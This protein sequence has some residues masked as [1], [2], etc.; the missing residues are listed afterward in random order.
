MNRRE[1][2]LGAMMIASSPIIGA[3]S[4]ASQ[5][6]IRKSKILHEVYARGEKVGEFQISLEQSPDR[7]AANVDI[8][9]QV[10][11]IGIPVYSYALSAKEIWKDGILHSLNSTV[12]AGRKKREIVAEYDGKQIL[13][14]SA[15]F[16]GV[17]DRNSATTSYFSK[18]MLKR[19]TWIS[20]DSGKP[21]NVSA[22]KSG[23]E[24]IKGI[25][26]EVWKVTGDLELDLFYSKDG[27]WAGSRFDIKGE[28]GLVLPNR[29][30]DFSPTLA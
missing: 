27:K 2:I 24:N 1:L 14:D 9:I 23:I 8:D 7:L 13:V 21:Y 5:V 11:I 28:T 22:N 12:S 10:N 26:Y 16:S 20:T 25:D 19:K 17:V 3:P 15:R 18:D 29:L 4:Y 30:S 6:G